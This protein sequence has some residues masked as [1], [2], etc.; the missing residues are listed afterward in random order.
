MTH[1]YQIHS[2][3]EGTRVSRI[4][5]LVFESIIHVNKPRTSKFV[6]RFRSNILIASS[7]SPAWHLFHLLTI[8][9]NTIC[10]LVV[11]VLLLSHDVLFTFDLVQFH[12][13]SISYSA[14]V[15]SVFIIL[16]CS[17]AFICVHII[18]CLSKLLTFDKFVSQNFILVCIWFFTKKFL[19]PPFCS[20]TC[21]YFCCKLPLFSKIRLVNN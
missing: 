15:Y 2:S 6:V 9:L 5:Y 11:F 14:L 13:L 16:L 4:S 3:M 7:H 20:H 10:I 1:F 12:T 8:V 21:V 17:V 18:D 19:Q